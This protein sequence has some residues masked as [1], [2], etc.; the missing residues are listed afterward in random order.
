MLKG[1][2]GLCSR[3]IPA[4]RKILFEEYH[5]DISILSNIGRFLI[6]HIESIDS[7]CSSSATESMNYLSAFQ[8]EAGTF[9]NLCNAV[10]Q[11]SIRQSIT[12][13]IQNLNDQDRIY[14]GVVLLKAILRPMLPL[15]FP[16]IR[17]GLQNGHIIIDCAF[18]RIGDNDP[19]LQKA[20]SSHLIRRHDRF[21]NCRGCAFDQRIES[22][23]SSGHADDN[24]HGR[25]AIRIAALDELLHYRG[26][27]TGL[28]SLHATVRF[29]DD[30]VQPVTL[31]PDSICKRLPDCISPAITIFRELGGD[32]QLLRI[33]KINMTVLKYFFIKGFLGNRNTLRQLDLI[34][35]GVDLLL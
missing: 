3:T 26:G 9:L 13:S 28:T 32:R 21:V 4:S 11:I 22:L 8:L 25:D 24:R 5:A 34:S 30:K 31:F 2:H 16:V 35:L 15:F 17:S 33:Q 7:Q 19:I 23:R 10:V 12:G 6:A 27:L 1:H 18:L 20:G 14:I 29:I